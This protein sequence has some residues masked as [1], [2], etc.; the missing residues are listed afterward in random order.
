MKFCPNCGAKVLIENAKF[1]MECGTSFKDYADSVDGVKEEPHNDFFSEAAESS[2][3]ENDGGFFSEMGEAVKEEDSANKKLIEDATKYYT[4]GDVRTA[5]RILSD[6]KNRD[7]K[8]T[9]MLAVIY[10][11]GGDGIYKDPDK[12]LELLKRAGMSGI[13]CVNF[14]I[15]FIG[16]DEN[17]P[18]YKEFIQKLSVELPKVENECQSPFDEVILGAFYM[19]NTRYQDFRKAKMYLDKAAS[20]GMWSAE[21]LLGTGYENGVFG[22]VDYNK[23]YQCYEKAAK[24]GYAEAARDLGAMLYWGNGCNANHK[25]AKKWYLVGAR[26]NEPL[27]VHQVGIICEEEQNYHEA[28]KWFERAISLPNNPYFENAC[29][30]LGILLLNGNDNPAIPT[31]HLRGYQLIRKALSL[32]SK[33][34]HALLGLAMCYGCEDIPEMANID[35]EQRYAMFKQYCNK[36]IRYSEGAI[37]EEAQATLNQLE[38][39]E[40]ESAN[41]QSEGCFI[42]TA[43]CYTFG[44]SDDCYELVMFRDFRDKWLALQIDGKSLI[45]EYYVVAPKIVLAINKLSNAKE[46]YQEIWDNYLAKCLQYIEQGQQ[47]ACK[48]KYVDMVNCLRKKYLDNKDE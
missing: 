15:E 18:Q 14:F 17:N 33:N 3:S 48:E 45:N 16:S 46:I 47:M 34:G 11:L 26:Q 22:G 23:V 20:H 8:A 39:M 9:H 5:E 38:K 19:Y 2:T 12:V 37:K 4:R 30:E 35:P 29:T 44:K 32:N 25:E 13:I 24:K 36:A 1:C 7:R 43:V 27:C 41:K 10:E 40:R 31:N 6:I 28:I 42:T 21:Y